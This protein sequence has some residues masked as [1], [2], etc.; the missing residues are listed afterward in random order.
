MRREG[1][2]LEYATFT[3][4]PDGPPLYENTL[5]YAIRSR[6]WPPQ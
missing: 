6:E 1:L 5:Q 2:F 4:A 3:S